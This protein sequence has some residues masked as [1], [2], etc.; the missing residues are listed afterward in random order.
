MERYEIRVTRDKRR[1]NLQ[2][3]LRRHSIRQNA[4]AEEADMENWQVSEMCTGRAN[5]MLLSTS[6]RLCN[7]LNDLILEDNIQYTIHD[8]FGD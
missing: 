1:T 8:I 5:D 7:A 2:V 6:K 4:L 3:I